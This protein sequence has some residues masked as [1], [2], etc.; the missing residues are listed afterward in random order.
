AEAELA[1]RKA[2]AN[3]LA[4]LAHVSPDSA[5]NTTNKV[6]A[7]PA[8]KIAEYKRLLNHLDSLYKREQ[9]DSLTYTPESAWMN[10]LRKQ[11][12]NN[13]VVKQQL[14]KEHPGLVVV[15]VSESKRIEAGS[16]PRV[17]CAAE[18]ARVSALN[19]NIAVLNGQ[20]ERLQKEAATVS[21]AEGA[22]TKLQ[23]QKE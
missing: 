6:A 4:N 2:A 8:E 9:D 19:S 14:E 18:A 1:E 7:V 11:I 12:T 17:E 23:L 15:G 5:T 10:A 22:I 3:E 16:N 20:L 13:V 21:G